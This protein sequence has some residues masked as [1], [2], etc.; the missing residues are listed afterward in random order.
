[1]IHQ[2]KRI[3]IVSLN[4]VEISLRYL[5][6]IEVKKEIIKHFASLLP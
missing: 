1:M 3:A 5:S 4:L 2:L 6:S